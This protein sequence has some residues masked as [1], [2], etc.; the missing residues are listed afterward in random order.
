MS[1]VCFERLA[2]LESKLVGKIGIFCGILVGLF[3]WNVCKGLA[4]FY[5]VAKLYA[6]ESEYSFSKLFE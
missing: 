3:K 2:E 5:Y 6:L 1:F 4:F